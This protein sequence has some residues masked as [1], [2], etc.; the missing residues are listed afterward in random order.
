MIDYPFSTILIN[1]RE[2][3]LEEI[4]SG[5]ENAQSDFEKSTFAFIKKWF[6]GADLFYQKTSGSTGTPKEIPISR[7]QMR[8]SAMLTETALQLKEG[9]TALVCLD[10]QYIAGKMMLVR[11]F[12]TGMKIIAVNPSANPL[13]NLPHYQKMDFAAFVPY[14]IQEMLSKDSAI[15]LNK[16]QTAIIGGTVLDNGTRNILQEFDCQFYATYGMT[17]TVSHIALQKLNGENASDF[18][19]VLPNIEIKLDNRNCLII[20]SPFLNDSIYTNDVVDIK[21][22]TSFKL[23]GRYDNVI[24]SGGVKISPEKVEIQIGDILNEVGLGQSFFVAGVPDSRLGQKIVL[25]IESDKYAIE[26]L[27]KIN[28]MFK[29]RLSSYEIPKE[30]VFLKTF[31]FTTTGK[32]NRIKTIELVK[33]QS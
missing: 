11:S 25:I 33:N 28:S 29:Q 18:F 23:I 14:Q 20:N 19:Q 10:T 5:K 22:L 8:S 26:V 24:N 1:N 17:E 31:L 2:V 32:V 7:D 16:I 6:T 3:D 21:S 9:F 30:I 4:I 27:E 12:V 15:K 13:L